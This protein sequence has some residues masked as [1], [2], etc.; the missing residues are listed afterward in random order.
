MKVLQVN[1]FFHVRGG[2]ERYYFDLC[3][4]LASRGHTVSHFSMRDQRNRH[5]A[6]E[7][8]FVSG[9]DLNS[10]E[11][12][13]SKARAAARILYSREAKSKIGQLMDARR[14]DVVHLHN[15]SRQLSPSV[16]DAAHARSI[17][18]I[19]TV[20]D[21]FLVCPA[22]TFFVNGS[23]CEDCGQG[24]FW[25]AAEK[26][27][28]DGT[29][30]SSLLGAFEAYLHGWL[31]LY[32]K[33]RRFIAPSLFMKSKVASLGWAADRVTHLPYF[34]PL[35]PDWS[36]RSE[37]YVLFAG[38]M[39]SE[40]G[41]GTL[42][43]AASIC[44]A[45]EFVLAGEGSGL[46]QFRRHAR[47]LGLTNIRFTGYLE[48]DALERLL[49]GASC[50]VVPSL[51][52]ENLPLAILEAFSRGKPAVVADSGGNRELVKD[53]LTGY[54]FER[55]VAAS[56]ADGIERLCSDHASRVKMGKNAREVVATG[57]SPA[58]HYTRLVAIYEDVIK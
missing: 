1:K 33:V 13:T 19:Q 17:P 40:K 18:T 41:V 15:I 8:Y 34:I 26:R 21:F 44:K 12:L 22:H 11:G 58:G 27:C 30:V 37:G 51:S 53:G 31:G 3:D 55:G 29:A 35:G 57:Y 32:K 42:I 6:D 24:S 7:A 39:T 52:Y 38:R 9:I 2:S 43:E 20:H 45:A 56:L 14:P 23:P 36:E 48:G 47:R 5:S 50:V 49:A 10:C 54:V 28:I 25:H 16:I 4:L 46:E